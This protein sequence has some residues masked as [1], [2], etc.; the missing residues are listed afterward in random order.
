MADTNALDAILATANEKGMCTV[1]A[2]KDGV[3]DN[4]HTYKAGQSFHM[5]KDL[6]PAHLAAGQ[7][8]PDAG[9]AKAAETPA[10]K[11]QKTTKSK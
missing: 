9:E 11:Q 2:A 5:H 7:I 3:T 10:D 6:I 4:G 1:R 8:A